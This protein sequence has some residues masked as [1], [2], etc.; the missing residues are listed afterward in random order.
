[1]STETK[2]FNLEAV[3]GTDDMELVKKWGLDPAVAYTEDI[4]MAMADAI[5]TNNYKVEYKDGI[6]KGLSEKEADNRA[7][8]IAAEGYKIAKKN[9]ANRVA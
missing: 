5:K 4:N 8:K 7:N 6:D 3:A 2:S 9:I 1:M